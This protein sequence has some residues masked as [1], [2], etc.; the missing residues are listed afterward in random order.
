ME[1]IRRTQMVERYKVLWE[2]GEGELVENKSRFIATTKPVESEEEALL[3]IESIRKKYWDARHNC[4]AYC[5]GDRNQI[6]RCSDDGE[7]SQTAGRP[8]LDVL[9]GE[10]VHNI[11]VV[12][13]RYFGGTLLGTGGLVRAYSGAV[14]EGLKN[15]RIM[16]KCLGKRLDIVTDYNGIGKIQ[17]ILAQ[18]QITTLDTQYTD[19]VE[20]AVM[21]PYEEIGSLKA[22]LTEG[23]NGRAILTEGNEVY[24]GVIDGEVI[25]C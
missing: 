13:T 6:Q 17:Y 4:F 12:V 14:Q 15:S 9:L 11:C 7:P 5:I 3:F 18:R 10:E 1:S 2:G 22:E 19:K 23:T 16:E 24:Y 21:V 8:M 20:V 25:L